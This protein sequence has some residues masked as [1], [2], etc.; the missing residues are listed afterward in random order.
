MEWAYRMQP[1]QPP[2]TGGR[3]IIVPPNAKG[4]GVRGATAVLF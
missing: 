4:G 1:P 3:S 2:N